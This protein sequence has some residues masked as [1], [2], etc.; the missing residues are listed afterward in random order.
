MSRWAPRGRR[1]SE[2]QSLPRLGRGALG[3]EEP[4]GGSVLALYEASGSAQAGA[5]GV[6]PLLPAAAVPSRH[7]REGRQESVPGPEPDPGAS[8]SRP[9]RRRDTC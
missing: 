3:V 9:H 6:K 8:S 2:E 7:G 5:A 4:F 1:R